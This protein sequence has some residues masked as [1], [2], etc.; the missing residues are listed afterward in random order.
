MGPSR[1]EW[2]FFHGVLFVY[3][4]SPLVGTRPVRTLPDYRQ[5]FTSGT[6]Q[7]K[8]RSW[9]L[10]KFDRYRISLWWYLENS[11]ADLI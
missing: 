10:K 5:Q 3:R 2:L 11:I 4:F 1:R 9:C 6:W 7:Q 8:N